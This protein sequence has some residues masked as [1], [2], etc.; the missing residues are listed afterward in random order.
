M[1][2]VNDQANENDNTIHSS[3]NVCI[4]VRPLNYKEN[5][6]VYT[7]KRKN[8]IYKEEDQVTNFIVS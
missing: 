3:F 5:N 1:A 8:I 7:N 2:Q 6:A 4:R